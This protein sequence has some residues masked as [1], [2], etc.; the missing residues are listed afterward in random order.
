MSLRY[1]HAS[2]WLVLPLHLNSKAHLHMAN[3]Q[4]PFDIILCIR[5]MRSY[6]QSERL[7]YE[8]LQ[9]A[10]IT[11][12]RLKLVVKAYSLRSICSNVSRHDW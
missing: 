7:G 1:P 8:A 9:I 2:A 6:E 10:A 4:D 3:Q 11:V 12:V 5:R